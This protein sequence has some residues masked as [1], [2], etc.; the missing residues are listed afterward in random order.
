MFK[1]F[2]IADKKG[3]PKNSPVVPKD[4]KVKPHVHLGH[5]FLDI[6]TSLV[7]VFSDQYPEKSHFLCQVFSL[8]CAD[9]AD[10]W[11]SC[12]PMNTLIYSWHGNKVCVSC[13]APVLCQE[14][15]IKSWCV[16]PKTV[17]SL[18]LHL[19]FFSL[20]DTSFSF[21]ISTHIILS[22]FYLGR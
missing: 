22:W 3:L 17:H 12:V 20:K 1:H 21:K 14:P 5:F 18:F 15:C 2:H 7:P 16:A 6:A 11:C 19:I 13:S 9:S 4:R 10:V 8:R